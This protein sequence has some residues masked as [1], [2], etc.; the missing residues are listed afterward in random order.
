MAG[1]SGRNA[2]RCELSRF[3]IV[4]QSTSLSTMPYEHAFCTPRVLVVVLS[5]DIF[6]L[7]L[8][9]RARIGVFPYRVESH[10]QG[11]FA[12]QQSQTATVSQGRLCL[13]PHQHYCIVGV[14]RATA[15]RV[16][17]VCAHTREPSFSYCFPA[18]IGLLL[19]FLLRELCRLSVSKCSLGFILLLHWHCICCVEDCRCLRWMCNRGCI[20]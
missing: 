2:Q 18:Y 10:S 9:H 17:L 14:V 6:S 11:Y 3:A 1:V 20:Y 12:H 13:L 16:V 8:P 4:V 19:F 5:F 15:T 7:Y